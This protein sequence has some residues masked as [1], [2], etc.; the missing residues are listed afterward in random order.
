MTYQVTKVFPRLILDNGCQRNVAGAAWHREVQRRL[1][2]HGL[3]PVRINEQEDFQFGDDRVDTSVCSWLYP[4]GIHGNNGSINIAEVE[5]NC[6]GLMSHDT[7][8][9]LDIDLL[10]KRKAYNCHLFGIKDYPHEV[11]KSKHALIRIDWFGDLNNLDRKFFLESGTTEDNGD[12]IKIRKGTARRLRKAATMVTDIYDNTHDDCQQTSEPESSGPPSLCDSETETELPHESQ[13]TEDEDTEWEE[14]CCCITGVV[15]SKWTAPSLMEICSSSLRVTSL[16]QER[17]W[18]GQPALSVESGF[19]LTTSSGRDAAWNHLYKYKPDVLILAWPCDPWCSMQRINMAREPERRKRVLAKRKQ[20]R[21]LVR[22]MADVIAWQVSRGKWFLGENPVCSEVWKLPEFASILSQHYSWNTEMCQYDLTDPYTLKPMRKT[23]K[24]VSNSWYVSQECS[25]RCDNTHSHQVIESTT[26]DPET[27][28]SVRRSAYAAWYTIPFCTQVL[29]G[30]E[31]ELDYCPPYSKR[32]STF[33]TASGTSVTQNVLPE[34]YPLESILYST[35]TDQL[36]GNVLCDDFTAGWSET[37]FR[38]SWDAPIDV[39]SYHVCFSSLQPHIV[40]PAAKRPAEDQPATSP[41]RRLK[42]KQPGPDA[43]AFGKQVEKRDYDPGSVRYSPYLPK[44]GTAERNFDHW[45]Y[46][47]NRLIRHHVQHRSTA[48]TPCDWPEIES[49]KYGKQKWPTTRLSNERTTIVNVGKSSTSFKDNWRDPAFAHRVFD[50]CKEWTGKTIFTFL[51]EDAPSEKMSA[52]EAEE[53]FRKVE[54]E[55]RLRLGL[56]SRQKR[57]REESENLPSN[58][59]PRIAEAAREVSGRRITGKRSHLNMREMM[60][61]LHE[62]RSRL[63]DRIHGPRT[64]TVDGSVGPEPVGPPSS[65]S[66]ESEDGKEPAEVPSDVPILETEHDTT[67]PEPTFGRG[68][69]GHGSA[70][71]SSARARAAFERER[72]LVRESENSTHSVPNDLGLRGNSEENAMSLDRYLAAEDLAED[73]DLPLGD[74]DLPPSAR[75]CSRKL[76]RVV[77]RAHKNLGHPSSE[78]LVR[79][80]QTAK[81][82]PEMI[83]YA[84]HWKCPS[85]HRRRPPERMPRV[86]MP[87][88]ADR[89]GQVIGLDLKFPKDADGKQYVVL[90]VLDFAT[91]FN[92]FI[93]LPDKHAE[94][95]FKHLDRFWLLW[96]PSPDVIVFDKGTEYQGT[97]KDMAEKL[98]SRLK[99]VPTESPWQ[100]ALVERHGATLQDI[101]NIAVM[102]QGV[103]GFDE[104]EEACRHASMAKNR[105]PGRTGHSP[106]SIVFGF[107]ERLFASGLGHYLE[108]PDDAALS[109]AATDDVMKRSIAIREAA[110]KAVITLD[111]HTKWH[112]ACKTLSRS[113]NGPYFP[114]D[115]VF[116]W[117]RARS[118]KNL[119]G[120][121]ARLYERW[122]GVAVVVGRE[123][124]ANKTSS[125]YWISHGGELMLVSQHHLKFASPEER[126]AQDWIAG[127]MS[128]AFDELGKDVP[129]A[130]DL[131][132][133]EPLPPEAGVSSE[134]ID[135]REYFRAGGVQYPAP[136]QASEPEPAPSPTISE[137]GDQQHTLEPEFPEADVPRSFVEVPVPESEP[138]DEDPVSVHIVTHGHARRR[139]SV[140]LVRKKT[141]E[142][143]LLKWKVWSKDQRKGKELDPHWFDDAEKRAFAESDAKEWKSFLES[144]AAQIVQ[145]NEA[146]GVPKDRIFMIPARFVRTNKNK[147]GSLSAKSRLVLPG[148]RD[149]DGGKPI[150]EGGFRTDAPT[151]PQIGLHLLFSRAVR[152]KWALRTFDVKTAFLS[153]EHTDRELYFKPPKEGLPGVPAGCLIR[154]VKGI[155]GLKEAPRL[156]YLKAKETLIACGWEELS[157]AK[158]VFVCR[159]AK[160]QCVGMLVLHVDDACYGGSGPEYDACVAKTR[161]AFKLGSEKEWDFEFLG[162]HVVQHEDYSISVDQH[163]FVQGLHHIHIPKDRRRNSK[164]R[165]TAKEEHDYRSLVGQLAW[166]AR[167]SMPGLSYVVSDL[168]Q[169]VATATVEDLVACNNALKLAREMVA[170]GLRLEFPVLDDVDKEPTLFWTLSERKKKTLSR[171]TSNSRLGVA[172]VHDAS[173][174]QQPGEGSQYGY[175][176]LVGP[177]SLYESSKKCHLLDW[178]SSKIHRKVKS[179]LA[180]EAAGA[181]RAF[182]RATYL[183]CLMCEIERGRSPDWNEMVK[184]VPFALATDCKSLYEL[185]KNDG[186]L[187]DDRRVALDLLDVRDGLQHYGD[188]YRWIPTDHM[189]ADALTKRMPPDLL[190]KFLRDS[191]YTFKYDDRITNAKSLAN[192]QRKEAKRAAKEAKSVSCSKTF[193]VRHYRV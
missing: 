77:Q 181:S 71:E 98:S 10:T 160:G 110:L 63:R 106:R 79:V 137:F 187:P 88:R 191:E 74:D 66:P 85:C 172:A 104:M 39:E 29:R 108:R 118:P 64:E 43:G 178:S 171:D 128:K 189:L 92:V 169:R 93:L 24:L 78:A 70:K 115:Q 127:Q 37:D 51:P 95:V 76:R 23:T 12:P 5:S 97:F 3:R 4:V 9:T 72:G 89:F 133:S 163:A 145:P 143:L 49:A 2:Q 91:C 173:F 73:E 59:R 129:K 20:H 16:A 167:E 136:N 151:A 26:Y 25:R 113:N 6:P 111:H 14:G 30:F 82:V 119:K 55:R 17:G 190:I 192:R 101:L 174:M 146:F 87:Y 180:A 32:H 184:S 154:V 105:R 153:G 56:P 138:E 33:W 60:E 47:G 102:E 120:R 116:Y 122:R 148:H 44:S 112:E 8:A 139:K 21:S 147:E 177:T 94:T 141:Q 162:R 152:S 156:W 67:P 179:T 31:A 121:N 57:F 46:D 11:S 165:L 124:D 149:P 45:E 134:I 65:L 158:A 48:F 90:N 36:T 35:V 117:R 188:E 86:S 183:R 164:G 80:M 62:K 68:D 69:D 123:W 140:L 28:R 132:S 142:V 99:V 157:I 27:E 182:D 53:E 193:S 126:Y 18:Q 54:E 170:Q 114:G 75:K 58:Q 22:F 109:M 175:M 38:F 155:Y 131:R 50:I 96:A 19:D 34:N 176:L 42:F 159:N 107:D 52:A 135:D 84:K 185:C 61:K 83:E 13:P 100:N 41:K 130:V 15:D 144:G 166:P 81:C 40:L 103:R 168:Q 125:A 161:Q 1:A 7:M 186:K 150:E